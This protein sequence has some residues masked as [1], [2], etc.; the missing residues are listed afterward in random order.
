M[1]KEVSIIQRLA[2]KSDDKKVDIEWIVENNL[3]KTIENVDVVSQVNS[4]NFGNL[5][6]GEV[7]SIIFDLEIPDEESLKMDFGDD[8]TLPD[9]INL[10]KCVMSYTL[11]NKLYEVRSNELEI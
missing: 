2:L 9:K 3:N 11:E 5:E 6:A 8:A 10:G 4:H 1:T 7:K